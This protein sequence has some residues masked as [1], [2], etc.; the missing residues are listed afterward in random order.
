[1]HH[2]LWTKFEIS[3]HSIAASGIL[4]CSVHACCYTGVPTIIALSCSFQ[5][6]YVAVGMDLT[7]SGIEIQKMSH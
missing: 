1:M 5:Q 2:N 3:S 6:A 7:H 4:C